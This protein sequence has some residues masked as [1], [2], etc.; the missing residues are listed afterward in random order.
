MKARIVSALLG[1]SLLVTLAGCD[2]YD[3]SSDSLLRPPKTMGDEAE[4]EQLISASA[5][6]NYTLKYP[7]SGS[8]RSAVIMKDLN[9][10][11]IDEAIA[12]FRAK[13]ELTS[14][15]MLVMDERDGSWRISGDFVTE[16]T[17]VDCVEFS[18]IDEGS[19]LEIL[20]GYTTYTP[21]VNFL[22]CYSFEN[23]TTTSIQSGQT[24]SSFCCGNLDGDGKNEV[25]T[26]SLYNTDNEARATM[27]AYSPD[28][29]AL[30]AKSTV[31]MDPNVVRYKSVVFTDI[32]TDV[33]GAAVDGTLAGEETETQLIYYNR[34]LATLR[35]P[36]Y[37]EKEK[38]STLRSCSV[39]CTD[40][41]NESSIEVPQIE[42]LPHE[43]AEDA[44]SVADKIIWC[45]FD[46]SNESLVPKLSMAANYT[47]NYTIKIPTA[48]ESGTYSAMNSDGDSSMTFCEWYARSKGQSLFE[49]KVFEA[50]AWDRGNETDDYTL[51]YRDNR[52]A[53]SYRSFDADSPLALSDDE[54]KKAFSLLTPNI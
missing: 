15:H 25:L 4:I 13:D 40:V 9:G 34:E 30:Y 24:Y 14:V 23:E 44:A 10:D 39:V 50:A 27:L 42:K 54:I 3:L 21:N 8:Y 46:V 37:R 35:N 52:Y 17:D 48:W 32:A 22:M 31:A 19:S 45:G 16:T 41:D 49:I 36:L 1:A 47:Y 5:E 11:D 20:A 51:I 7:K 33:K 38:N 29:K 43:G 28:K 18:D 53:Y 26:L 12:F 2:F 6:G